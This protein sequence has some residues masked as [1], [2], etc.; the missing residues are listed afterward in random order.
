MLIVS[1][2]MQM[3]TNSK[4][5]NAC[6]KHRVYLSQNTNAHKNQNARSKHAPSICVTLVLP[7]SKKILNIYIIYI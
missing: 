5:Q 6:F 7:S 4:M 2:Q 1:N 3:L